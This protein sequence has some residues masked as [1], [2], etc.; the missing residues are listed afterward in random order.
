[1]PE[2]GGSLKALNLS[3]NKITVLERNAF[4]KLVKIGQENITSGQKVAGYIN[5][6]A[7]VGQRYLKMID[8]SANN[9]FSV[10]PEVFAFTPRLM[11]LSLSN[12]SRL[13]LPEN[14]SLFIPKSTVILNL[15]Y[16]NI[17]KIYE[18]SFK[19]GKIGLQELY[20]QHNIISAVH[21]NAFT[22][23]ENLLVLD[24]S[25]NRLLYIE[26]N[27]ILPL[28]HMNN[29][30]L[31]NNPWLCGCYVQFVYNWSINQGVQLGSVTCHMSQNDNYLSWSNQI[32]RIQCDK[33]TARIRRH[34]SRETSSDFGSKETDNGTEI[35]LIVVGILAAIAILIV[36]CACLLDNSHEC[37]EA[38]GC[39]MI[40]H[41]CYQ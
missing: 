40:C 30:K 39:L 22:S 9:I 16:C 23:F 14:V 31:E 5:Q 34:A 25:H 13:H 26:L 4:Y 3:H 21:G 2:L 10:H 6:Y 15:S 19:K 1:M 37:M 12:N 24:L 32:S 18:H 28:G 27:V 35:I 17:S 36:L 41:H 7:F 11:W 8:L 29:L 33:R 20:L 38:A